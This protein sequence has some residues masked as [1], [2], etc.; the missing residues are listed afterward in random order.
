MV[1]GG[2]EAL[3]DECLCCREGKLME[4]EILSGKRNL[5]RSSYL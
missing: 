5:G 2:G 4:G 3:T 1:G